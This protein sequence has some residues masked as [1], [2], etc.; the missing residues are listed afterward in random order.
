VGERGEGRKRGEKG[1]RRERE[2][3]VEN[4]ILKSVVIISFVSPLFF[5]K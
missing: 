4:F 3:A 1:G 2:F 5:L